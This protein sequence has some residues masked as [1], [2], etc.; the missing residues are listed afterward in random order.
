MQEKI[1]ALNPQ[2]AEIE[3]GVRSLK[4]ITIYPLSLSDQ[5]EMTDLITETMTAFFNKEGQTDIEFV[6]FMVD[7]IKNN[8]SKLLGRC[9]DMD[10]AD[11]IKY[12]SNLQA[13][14]LADLLFE[15]NYKDA[16][17]NVIGLREKIKGVLPSQ[18]L[19]QPSASG[20]PLMDLNI[21]S[22]SPSEKG[23]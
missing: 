17:K 9:S 3:I 15:V 12:I 4:K 7:L 14:Q 1:E 16:L 8:L 23:A 19:S 13:T 18:K 10:G 5:L 2:I 21:S 22:E 6:T 11:I 20:T